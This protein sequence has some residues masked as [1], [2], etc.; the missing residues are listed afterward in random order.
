MK[1]NDVNSFN[2]SINN[3]K[4]LITYFQDENHKPKKNYKK[5]KMLTTI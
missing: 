3:I 2:N 4:E 5:F 1:L